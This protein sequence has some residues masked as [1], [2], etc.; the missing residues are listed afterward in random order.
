MFR[1]FGRAPAPRVDPEPPVPFGLTTGW[2]A[3]PSQDAA[4]VARA[5]G[6]TRIAPVGWQAG[7]DRVHGGVTHEVLVIPPVAGWVLVLTGLPLSIDTAARRMALLAHLGALER[8]FG[9][10]QHFRSDPGAEA[11]SWVRMERGQVTRAFGWS[12]SAGVVWV[13]HGPTG[14][15]E[16]AAGMPDL[17]GMPLDAARGAVCAWIQ[18]GFG[19][20]DAAMPARI[21]GG[22]SID[23]LGLSGPPS[24]C[25]I[26]ALPR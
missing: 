10:A 19:D 23:P 17:T 3:A 5:L 14:P 11:V 25:L 8:R 6:L 9:A 7:S 24:T 18:A 4:A 15:A 22:W 20:L 21:A 26:G 12:G 13:N 1:L 2:F 16:I